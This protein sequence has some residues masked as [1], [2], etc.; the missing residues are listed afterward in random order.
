VKGVCQ[1]QDIVF[2]SQQTETAASV[3]ETN[4][5]GKGERKAF[6]SMK[7]EV[8]SVNGMQTETL[9]SLM[10]DF[11]KE[12][13]DTILCISIKLS[14]LLGYKKTSEVLGVVRFVLTYV[15]GVLS[16]VELRYQEDLTNAQTLLGDKFN[17]EEFDL[18]YHIQGNRRDH[19]IRTV[20]TNYNTVE[21]LKYLMEA[22]ERLFGSA[23]RESNSGDNAGVDSVTENF[24]SEARESNSGDNAGVDSVT[25][26]ASTGLSHDSNLDSGDE[27]IHKDAS[28][29]ENVCSSDEVKVIDEESDDKTQ[30]LYKKYRDFKRDGDLS[31]SE[32]YEIVREVTGLY[33]HKRDTMLFRDGA[34]T[35]VWITDPC[36][37]PITV[38]VYSN[39]HTNT[40]TASII[41]G[42]S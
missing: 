33:I 39:T 18:E 25:E 35:F 1:K 30:S 19:F 24:G 20:L 42:S 38:I 14:D 26:N 36:I 16:E 34:H 32:I 22:F 6:D 7:N 11:A 23:A 3:S 41:F 15:K 8:Y 29:T 37:E 2:K 13:H 5:S 27:A 4:S 21:A 31:N 12:H 9:T 10:M 40:V 17:R 28:T